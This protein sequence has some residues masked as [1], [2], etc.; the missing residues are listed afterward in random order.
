MSLQHTDS[1]SRVLAR[2]ALPP[3]VEP[4][5]PIPEFLAQKLPSGRPRY[6][7]RAHLYKL[8]AL[9]KVKFKYS[10][11]KPF[12]DMVSWYAHLED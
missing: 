8:R 1:T 3:G 12:V 4:F 6:C 9:G 11:N 2:V 10:N 5:L 7:S